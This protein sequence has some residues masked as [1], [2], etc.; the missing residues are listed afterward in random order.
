MS[1]KGVYTALSG[2]IAQSQR[3]DTIANNLANV[4]TPGFKRDQQLFREFLTANERPAEVIQVPRIPASIESFYDMQGGDKSYVD[5]NGTYTDFSQGGLRPTGNHLDVAL[6]GKGFFEIATPAGMR[7]TRHGAFSLDG[8]GTLVTRDGFPVM[9]EGVPGQDPA[10]RRIQTTG[11][12]LT[13]TDNGDVLEENKKIG[14]LSVVEVEK[15]E[16]LQ[17]VGNNLYN[18]R[19]D[20]LPESTVVQNPSLR[21]G[22]VEVSN[23]KIVKEMT[24]MIAA[25]RVFESTQKAISAYDSMTEK[26]VNQVPKT[27][28]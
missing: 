14:R 7:M 1:T 23:V 27:S 10:T 5:S 28:G 13:I 11:G 8:N 25:S 2:A 18:F 12:S 20:V 26:L 4:N 6:D 22:Y 9:S 21:Q 19:A 3:L 24:D 15:K 16:N 17:K